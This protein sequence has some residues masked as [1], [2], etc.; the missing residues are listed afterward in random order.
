MDNEKLPR[1]CQLPPRRDVHQLWKESVSFFQDY[2]HIF[3]TCKTT[4]LIRETIPVVSQY[5]VNV[6]RLEKGFCNCF[7]YLHPELLHAIHPLLVL[8]G[9]YNCTQN[10]ERK[11]ITEKEKTCKFLEGTYASLHKNMPQQ[12]MFLTLSLQGSFW[13]AQ[14]QLA[15]NGSLCGNLKM[16]RKP[17]MHGFI[18]TLVIKLV[19]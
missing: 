7:C 2:Q 8:G 11:Q 16:T 19:F 14:K 10:L 12:N 18:I 9:R 1:A 13:S 3:Q 4:E 6:S 15:Q 17:A 5:K